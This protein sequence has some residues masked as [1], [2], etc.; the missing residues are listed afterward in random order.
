LKGEGIDSAV[1]EVAPEEG[2]PDGALDEMRA[3]MDMVFDEY[4]FEVGH[5]V[6]SGVQLRP[7][8]IERI[9]IEEAID[10]EDSSK[11]GL[12]ILQDLT[13]YYRAIGVDEMV[14]SDTDFSMVINQ[15]GMKQEMSGG[16]E[17]VAYSGWYGG[18]IDSSLMT[19]FSMNQNIDMR[20]AN[21]DMREAFE[22][23]ESARANSP[24]FFQ[25]MDMEF[26]INSAEFTGMKLDKLMRLAAMGEWP[27]PDITD[28]MAYGRIDM[29]GMDMSLN[30]ATF[31]AIE[32]M[33]LDLSEWH[34]F[35][36]TMQMMR[37]ALEAD[38]PEA[39]V[40]VEKVMEIASEYDALPIL[41]DQTY[42]WDWSPETGAFAFKAPQTHRTF[43]RANFEISGFLPT[44]EDGVAAS[45][46]IPGFRRVAGAG[47]SGRARQV[48]SD[49]Q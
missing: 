28:L 45:K 30:G 31:F 23:F 29:R 2:M 21:I 19:G 1:A 40:V 15:T 8:E 3:A 25:Q 46:L 35:I 5:L 37:P 20:E 44:Y 36:P 42:L 47:R 17:L 39:L 48:V 49:G 6:A 9:D 4:I 11:A 34:W 14:W 12:F 32:K 13:A 22:G 43:G 18:D 26:S 24:E 7:W 16:Y 27:T 33:V 41:Y 38:D 10:G